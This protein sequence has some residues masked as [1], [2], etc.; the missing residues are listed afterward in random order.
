LTQHNDL[1]RTGQ[2]LNETILTQASVS[3]GDF[4]T[5]Y[6][7]AVDGQIL[8]QPLYLP[9]LTL[10][11]GSAA[12]N[13]LFVATEHDSVYAFDA[14]VGTALSKASLLD[15]AHGASARATT[16]PDS[17]TAWTNISPEYGIT[18][19]PVIKPGIGYSLYSFGQL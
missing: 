1:A 5:L 17:D 9:G 14:D 4:G 15:A 3:S 2:N 12:H 11:G 7:L 8:A 10:A 19:T 16:D 13:V 6:R 18:G